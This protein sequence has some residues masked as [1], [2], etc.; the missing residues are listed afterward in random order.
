MSTESPLALEELINYISDNI[1][2][3]DGES[4]IAK[5]DFSII[6]D[7]ETKSRVL[8]VSIELGS[9]ATGVVKTISKLID[10]ETSFDIELLDLS[11]EIQN[12]VRG[13]GVEIADFARDQLDAEDRLLS[14]LL[15]TLIADVAQSALLS[16]LATVFEDAIV[17]LEFPE[18]AG[19]VNAFEGAFGSVKDG[20]F[21]DAAA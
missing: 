2:G 21:P 9:L 6:F 4:A 13:I 16:D 3:L 18:K 5:T 15:D 12:A 10:L 11:A 7:E 17:D 14:T 1:L 19:I 20:L 8:S